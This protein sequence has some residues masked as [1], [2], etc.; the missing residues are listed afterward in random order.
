MNCPKCNAENEATSKFCTSCGWDLTKI[1]LPSSTESLKYIGIIALM[2]PLMD[3]IM[4]IHYKIFLLIYT[5]DN[6]SKLFD[7][8]IFKSSNALLATIN[9]ALP[10]LLVI[11]IKNLWIKIAVILI[12]AILLIFQLLAIFDIYNWYTFWNRS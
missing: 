6:Y 8:I 2:F 9:Y 3:L 5:G 10:V 4:K 11:K 1:S 12:S 7:S